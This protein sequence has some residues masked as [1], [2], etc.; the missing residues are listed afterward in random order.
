M[1]RDEVLNLEL[2]DDERLLLLTGLLEFGGPALGARVVAPIVGAQSVDEFFALTDRLRAAITDR[3]PLT[4]T[5]WTRAL[6]LTEICW[7]SEVLG[8]ASE[9]HSTMSDAE[10][11]RS[12]RSVQRKIVTGERIRALIDP[13][14]T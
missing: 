9:F 3:K 13:D 7:A 12:L 1:P 2:T 5:D 8:A 6:V 10:A 11:L 4:G 14:V